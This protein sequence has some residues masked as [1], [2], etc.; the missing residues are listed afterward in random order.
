MNTGM[1]RK[2]RPKQQEDAGECKRL[3]GKRKS[4]GN[5]KKVFNGG[6]RISLCCLKYYS[7]P[8]LLPNWGQCFS[9]S[10]LPCLSP[11]S[12]HTLLS[13]GCRA[14]LNHSTKVDESYPPQGSYFIPHP[15]FLSR[16][17]I[18]SVQDLPLLLTWQ[19]Q[20]F[21]WDPTL[22]LRSLL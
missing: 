15:H 22:D 4:L 13:Y 10:L 18:S 19:G 8:L 21:H 9:V 14:S 20:G 2:G 3:W 5:W 1:D 12:Q 16:T 7:G 6:S 17:I 11:P